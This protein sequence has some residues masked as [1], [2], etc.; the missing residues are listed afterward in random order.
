LPDNIFEHPEVI[1]ASVNT[2]QNIPA[3]LWP[4]TEFFRS[5][6]DVETRPGQEIVFRVVFPVMLDAA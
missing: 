3:I 6:L 4:S 5:L 1:P 2:V